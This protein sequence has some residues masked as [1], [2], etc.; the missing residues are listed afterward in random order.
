MRTHILLVFVLFCKSA[1]A[2]DLITDGSIELP[3]NPTASE[4]EN[5]AL[6]AGSGA[7]VDNSTFWGSRTYIDDGVPIHSPD[8]IW[9]PSY[10]EGGATASCPVVFDGYGSNS[11]KFIRSGVGDFE[12]FEQAINEPRKGSATYIVSMG[13]R[14]DNNTGSN[15]YCKPTDDNLTVGMYFAKNEI[16]FKSEDNAEDYNECSSDYRT[17]KR[18][19][20]N[21]ISTYTYNVD[22]N[23]LWLTND[24]VPIELSVTADLYDKQWFGIM[25][26]TESYSNCGRYDILYFDGITINTPECYCP[27]DKWIQNQAYVSATTI[28]AGDVIKAGYDVGALTSVGEVV[29]YSS[30]QVTYQAGSQINLEPGF[31]AIDG[32]SFDAHI[33]PCSIQGGDI[34][35]AYTTG[36]CCENPF[37]SFYSRNATWFSLDVV[38]ENGAL[39]NHSGSVTSG[40]WTYIDIDDIGVCGNDCNCGTYVCYLTLYNCKAKYYEEFSVSYLVCEEYKKSQDSIRNDKYISV[41]PNPFNS[42]LEITLESVNTNSAESV[43]VEL[44]NVQGQLIIKEQRKVFDHK[45]IIQTAELLDG[46]YFLK[47]SYKDSRFSKNVLKITK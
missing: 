40:T 8:W 44:Y 18:G 20:Y 6:P 36:V 14:T 5:S 30:N 37:W 1:V 19:V 21:D 15:S 34:Y 46:L 43:N 3:L 42:E 7:N 10:T 22:M 29:V 38:G 4:F 32:S 12:L 25:P 23:K 2:Q 41:N 16:K 33:A 31:I 11:H 9:Y 13:I 35:L 27:V 45:V 26:G 28:Q 24:W 39:H 17:F 47:V